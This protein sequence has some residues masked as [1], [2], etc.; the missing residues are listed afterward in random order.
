LA[1]GVCA[2]TQAAAAVRVGAES[3]VALG[4]ETAWLVAWHKTRILDVVDRQMP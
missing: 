3:G 2:V 4:D 1:A